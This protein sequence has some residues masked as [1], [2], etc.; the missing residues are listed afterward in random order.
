MSK[1]FAGGLQPLKRDTTILSD[2]GFLS[3]HSPQLKIGNAQSLVFKPEDSGPCYLLSED[4]QRQ[5]PQTSNWE[6]EGGRTVKEDACGSSY[7]SWCH[8]P[9]EPK[10]C[11]KEFQ[12]FA[13]NKICLSI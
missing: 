5:M 1:N 11:Q 4:R 9:A 8:I 10:P 12:E 2:S 7:Y 6:K 13:R 3:P